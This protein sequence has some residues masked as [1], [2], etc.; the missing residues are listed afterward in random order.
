MVIAMGARFLKECKES[1]FALDLLQT[2][3]GQY[4]DVKWLGNQKLSVH[5][6]F[7][8]TTLDISLLFIRHIDRS[9]YGSAN[10]LN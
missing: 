2:Q 3:V 1:W 6:L 7:T 9:V 5:S 8:K 4:W 10:D